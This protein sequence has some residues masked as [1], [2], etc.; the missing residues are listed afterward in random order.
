M[1]PRSIALFGAT[2]LVGRECLRLLLDRQEFARVVVVTRRDLPL[3]ITPPQRM[4]LELQVVDFARLAEHAHL[5]RVDQVLCSLGT[6]IRKAGSQPAFRVVDFDYPL[7]IAR[8][9]VE[10]G[11]RHFLLVSAL[12]AN[13]RSAAFYNRVKG[14]LEDAVR[15]LPYRSHTIVRPSLLLG[16]RAEFRLG[17][18]VAAHLGFLAPRKYQPVAARDVARALVE[19][20][21]TDLPGVKVIESAQIERH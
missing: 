5:L 19:A 21:A 14:E 7:Q 3:D 4:K 9:G 11:A 15:A 17:E 13:A 2:G 18:R 1:T 8:L 20:A 12:G 6:T 10:Q 16:E